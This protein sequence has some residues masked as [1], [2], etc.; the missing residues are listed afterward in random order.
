V[1]VGTDGSESASAAVAH[2]VRIAHGLGAE[3]LLVHA[4]PAPRPSP[5][6][7]D[8]DDSFP[9]ADVGKAILAGEERIHQG[10]GVPIR[11]VLRKG[12]PAEVL[13]D[14]ADEERTDL[15]V[16]GSKGMSGGRRFLIGSVPNRVSQ[17][18]ACSVLIVHTD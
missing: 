7:F 6:P 10:A 2:A 13:L 18:A 15:I 8:F 14:L 12:D 16:V 3:L 9:A 1:I 4:Y 11:T 17:H 5:P